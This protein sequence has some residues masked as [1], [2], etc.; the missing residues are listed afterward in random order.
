MQKF[1]QPTTYENIILTILTV[2][3]AK[4]KRINIVIHWYIEQWNRG[5]NWSEV[6]Y[7]HSIFSIMKQRKN[8]EC[9]FTL[10]RRR[11]CAFVWKTVE[12]KKIIIILLA[13]TNT[14]IINRI[15]YLIQ[16]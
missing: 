16:N 10:Y 11:V 9:F 7:I 8:A 3:D 14:A 13:E 6:I 5:K 12:R 2:I 15:I 1:N 4:K